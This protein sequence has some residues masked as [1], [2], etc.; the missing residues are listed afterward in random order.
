MSA[1]ESSASCMVPMFMK[2]KHMPQGHCRASKIA[3]GR[4]A[5]CK[6]AGVHFFFLLQTFAGLR[7]RARVW[8]QTWCPS[9]ENL[10]L[11][12]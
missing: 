10:Q 3:D 7:S 9:Q 5:L 2:L 1:A 6:S 4:E 8:I 11:V 12:T